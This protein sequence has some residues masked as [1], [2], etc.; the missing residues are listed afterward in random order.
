MVVH[1]SDEGL[2]LDYA[3]GALGEALS[4]A[5]ATH[6]SLS[7]KDAQEYQALNSVGGVMLDDIDCEPMHGDDDMG[8]DAVLA[9]LDDEPVTGKPV[10]FNSVT[11]DIIPAPLRD[12]IPADLNKLKW[13]KAG[14]GVEEYRIKTSEGDGRTA[15]LRI[16]PGR[17]MPEHTH[18]G[19]EITVVLDGSYADG[20]ETFTRGDLQI[21]DA[22]DNH[23]PI[24]DA[25]EGCICLIVLD[26]PVKLT[27][28]V[29]R[30]LNPFVRF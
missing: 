25:R 10:S 3:S 15:L 30:L 5:M 29:G 14:P 11:T 13:R 26:A 23:Q 7:M 18:D 27:G 1:Q 4:L 8:L 9:R 28:R 17:A 2:M 12:Y 16:E 22:S 24:A 21:A 19:R 20:A 6:L